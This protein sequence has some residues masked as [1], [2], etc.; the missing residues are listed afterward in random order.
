MKERITIV[1]IAKMANVSTATVSRIINNIGTV[2]EAKR[3]KVL[4]IIDQY[5]YQPN[6]IAKALK[7]SRSNTVGFIVPHIN[8]PFY[9]EL[10][11]E[12]EL[13]A[14][15]HGYTLILCNSESNKDLESNILKEFIAAN[16]RAIVF[17]GGRLDDL[18]IRRD[19]LDEIEHT[20]QTIPVISGVAVPELQCIQIYQNEEKSSCDLLKHLAERGFTDVSLLGGQSNVR[21]TKRRREQFLNNAER[22]GISIREEVIDSDYSIEGGALAMR[23]LLGKG[24]L[25][26]AIICINDLVATGVLSVSQ[27]CGIGV[28]EDIAV[29][30][31]DNLLF[32]PYIFRGVTTIA[33]NYSKYAEHIVDA[34]DRIDEL[35]RHTV[36]E[37]PTSFIIRGTTDAARA[38]IT[39]GRL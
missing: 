29:I 1:E 37:V 7:V 31:F 18:H 36:V 5:D 4:E 32:S 13:C 2:S 28:P 8:S 33:C 34:I 26:Q 39:L 6:Q 14:Q 23:E 30:G 16:V 22:Y 19:F 10:F 20:N 9:A 24:S 35:D 21:T 15:K 3:K 25:P 17:M 11:Y 12:T 27:E 38:D